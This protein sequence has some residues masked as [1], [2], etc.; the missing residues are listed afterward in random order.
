MVQELYVGLDVGTS[1]TKCVVV[2]RAGKQV[3]AAQAAYPS[4]SPKPG[5]VEQDPGSWWEAVK[6]SVRQA[7]TGGL[8]KHVQG[9]G[10]TGQMHGLVALGKSQQC[11]RPAIIWADARSYQEVEKITAAAAATKSNLGGPVSTGFL[12][13]SLLWVKEH[14][15]Q[16]YEQIETVLTPKDYVRL[17]LTGTAIMDYTDACGTGAFDVKTQ[18]WERKLLGR[19]GIEASLFPPLA[20]SFEIVGYLR[21]EAAAELGLP[22]RIPVAAGC[23]DVQASAVGIG[24]TRPTQLLVN[25]GTGAQ[26]FQLIKGFHPDSNNRFHVMRHADGVH[27]HTHGAIL[28]GG[29]AIDWVAQVV[30]EHPSKILTDLGA[31]PAYESGLYFLPYL[32]G[33]RTPF[34]DSTLR[35][36]FIGLSVSHSSSDLAR[37]ALEGIGFALYHAYEVTQTAAQRAEVIRTGGGPLGEPKFRQLIADIF[38]LPLE[39][40]AEANTSAVGAALIGLAGATGQSLNECIAK[41]TR[42]PGRTEPDLKRHAR[43]QQGFARFKK[44]SSWFVQYQKEVSAENSSFTSCGAVVQ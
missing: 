37:A 13:P 15:P 40:S 22:A 19:L 20:A 17:L 44:L 6:Q 9:L 43:C 34:M 7:L 5:W 36:A 42:I 25:I 14:E 28:S 8:G 26:V 24:I 30:K 11:L 27:C 3:S 1:S 41:T 39:H 38:G 35:G 10:I 18:T 32:I 23:G 21:E 29:M 31:Q 33:E 4:N 2:D 12:L 16:I